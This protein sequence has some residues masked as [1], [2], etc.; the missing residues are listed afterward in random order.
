MFVLSTRIN[1][2]LSVLFVVSMGACGNFGG[3]SAC[4]ASAPL[5]AGG[6]PG[7]QTVEGG[8]QVRVTPQGFTKLTSVLPGIIN[9]AFAS[10]VCV[11][12]GQAGFTT[13]GLFTG[14]KY[15]NSTA[16]GCAPGCKLDVQL[17]NGASG[18]STS[19]VGSDL[20]LNLSTQVNAHFHGDAYV[21]SGHVASC[22]LT[23]TSNDL[24]GS[25]DIALGITPANGELNIHLDHINDFHLSLDFSGC[26]FVSSVA[27]FFT[28]VVDSILG[29]FIADL[30]T[31]IIDPLIQSFLPS[32]LGIASITDIGTLLSGVSPGT[33]ATLET[34][35]VPGGYANLVGNG[36]SLGIITGINSDSDLATRTGTRPDNVPYVSE[37]NTCVPPLPAADFAAAPHS[38]PQVN[39]SALTNPAKAFSLTA[40]NDFNGANETG[41]NV[42]DIKMGLSETMLDQ[43][44][45]HLVTSGA[46][47]LGV[48]TS[49]IQQL[50]VGTISLLVPSLGELQSAQGNDPL[51]LVTRP[52]RAL[53]FT[54]GDN[55]VASPAITIGISHLE[56]D[57]YAFLYE[58]YVRVLTMDLTMNVGVNL[59]LSQAP[60]QP[61]MVKPSL[62]GISSS[63]VQVTVLNSEFVKETPDH[64]QQVLPSVFDLVTP[65]LGNLQPIQLPSFAG[66]TLNNPTIAHVITNQDNFLAITASLGAGFAARQLAQTEPFAAAAV[67]ALDKDLAPTI[68][69]STGTAHLKQVATPAPDVVRAALAHETG[70]KLPEV[71]IDVDHV[72]AAGRE[73]EWSW[74]LNGGMYRGWSSASPLVIADRAFAWQGKFEVGL[75]SRVK[76]DMH[77]ESEPVRI[78]V[79]VDSVGPKIFEDQAAFDGDDFSA[80]VWDVVS[81]KEVQ[82]AFGRPGSDKPETAW[83]YQ[84]DAKLSRAE[85]QKLLFAGEVQMFARDEAGNL[86]VALVGFHGAG[87]AAGCTCN[88]TGTPGTGS[89]LMIGIVGA[90]LLRRRRRFSARTITSAPPFGGAAS[91]GKARLA[92][93]MITTV[94]LWAGAS[95]A[96]SMQPGCSCSDHTAACEQTADCTMCP[97]GEIPFCIDNTCVCSTDIPAGKVGPYSDVGVNAAGQVWVSAYAQSHGDLVVAHATGG[98]IPD[99]AWEWVDGIPD[100]PV[101]V[102]GSTIRG[103]IE[104]DGANV[105]MYTSI[106]VA[107]DSTVYVSYFDVD[108]GALK[109][110]VRGVDGTWTKTDVELATGAGDVG[111]AT[112]AVGM[113]TSLTLDPQGRPGIA[114]LAH[115]DDANGMR[116]EVH[117]AQANLVVPTGPTDWTVSLVD[118]GMIPADDPNNPNIY[119]L[120][121]GLGLFI[122]STRT[123]TGTP[124]VTYYDRSNGDL[125]VSKWDTA[126]NKFAAA[127]VLDGSNG[128]DVGWSPSVQVQPDGKVAVAYVSASTD[129]LKYIVEGGQP[130]VIDD[131]YRIVGTT[132]DGLP[133]PEYHFV[134]DD[135]GLVLANGV[136]QVLYQDATTQELLLATKGDMAWT[137]ESIAGATTPWP[138]A[139]GFFASDALSPSDLV[140]ST[141][142]IDQP[143]GENWVEVFTRPI[144]I[145]R[146]L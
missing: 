99:S 128:T 93:K 104:D 28:D 119:P 29:S 75:I 111:S 100:G 15:C 52:Q 138:G 103:G 53:D 19:V 67:R 92:I 95:V 96:A 143:T 3:C 27:N 133:K 42:P 50:N 89:L 41:A 71:T 14:L 110:A 97:E 38:L 73:L 10:G 43:L 64:L 36:L 123:P 77:T 127:V 55:T 124:V 33:K 114:Y 74:N 98:R 9:Q 35:V 26:G 117:F 60:G 113:Y 7:S 45:H 91:P 78:P 101:T 21:A 51:L 122:D 116:A 59:E 80:P 44:G 141:W 17:N 121:E 30:L 57:F 129:D 24:G 112:N 4:G 108:R 39:R 69:P 66:F 1:R 88:S 85:Y 31:P 2:I 16:N 109:L 23:A 140:M 102:P 118:T 68:A 56:V 137:H 84:A 47:C 18:F 87:G 134:G 139:Y 58:R 107:A 34:R 32:P 132:V 126:L 115:L 62:V 25:V 54:V 142:V 79:I 70:G 131:G 13:L 125:K 94:G 49:L 146:T 46:L 65:L 86:S 76:G 8:A 12:S 83:T 106:A 136:P 135:A 90:G 72:D 11:P 82:V 144:V 22:D 105:G 20:R 40:A 6:L 81:G 63:A 145:G 37:P 48:G 120:P 5:P 61:A 130:E